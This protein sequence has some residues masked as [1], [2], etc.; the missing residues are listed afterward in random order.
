MVTERLHLF[1][2]FQTLCGSVASVEDRGYV[3]DLG[4]KGVKAFLTEKDAEPCIKNGKSK[5]SS[6]FESLGPVYTEH[7]RQHWHVDA[8]DQFGIEIPFWSEQLGVLRNL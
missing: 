2:Y 6:D 4:V 8:P 3:I 7:Y 1:D 5:H